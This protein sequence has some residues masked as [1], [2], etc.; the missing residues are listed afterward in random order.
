VSNSDQFLF[1]TSF[2]E[3]LVAV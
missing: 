1:S 3:G 2:H